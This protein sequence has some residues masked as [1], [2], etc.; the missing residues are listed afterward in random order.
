MNQ[1][2]FTLEDGDGGE[3]RFLRTGQL[4]RYNNTLPVNNVEVGNRVRVAPW[5]SV[6]Q[7]FEGG[8]GQVIPVDNTNDGLPYPVLEIVN[9]PEYKLKDQL[10]YAVGGSQRQIYGLFADVEGANMHW[11]PLGGV[12]D[13]I[14]SLGSTDGNA[15]IIGTQPGNVYSF[16]T[17]TGNS[18]RMPMSLPN[19][20]SGSISRLVIQSSSLMFAL[21][22]S[23]FILIYDGS[24]WQ[25][26]SG[27]PQQSYSAL[28][29]DWTENPKTLYVATDT[30]VFSSSDNGKTWENQSTGLPARPHCSDIRFVA[31]ADGS[32]YLYLG[33][34]GR[35]SWRTLIPGPQRGGRVSPILGEIARVIYGVIQDGGGLTT[36]GP[37]PPWGPEGELVIATA[38]VLLTQTV[39]GEVGRSALLRSLQLLQRATTEM[40]ERSNV[41]QSRET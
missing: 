34:Y 18:N 6:S 13:D 10:M 37:V 32:K 17:A 23:G 20:A 24:P 7:Q 15:I 9:A 8:L 3:C 25:A 16:D 14:T 19:P 36:G 38:A 22:T 29:T 39:P 21:H 27:L 31:Q 35:S 2:W 30:S 26:V 5:N 11:T 40:L 28:E 1:P 41:T 4:L 33:T 12:S